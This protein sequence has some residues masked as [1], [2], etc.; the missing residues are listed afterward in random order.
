MLRIVTPTFDLV[1]LCDTNMYDKDFN[2]E[3]VAT[4][5]INVKDRSTESM[6]YTVERLDVQDLP[7]EPRR[8]GISTT[9]VVLAFPIPVGFPARPPTQLSFAFLPID[10]FGFRVSL[11]ASDRE[12]MARF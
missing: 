12:N 1:Y 6:K 3:T 7:L 8:E 10:N 11:P 4:F 2:G 5:V 9:V